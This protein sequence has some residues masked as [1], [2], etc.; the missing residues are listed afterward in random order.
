MRF[1]PNGPS[2]PDDLLVARDEGRVVFFC[3]A[4][5]SRARAGLA[6]FFGLAEAVLESLGVIAD[7]PAGKVLREAREIENRTGIGLVSADRI[8]GLLEREFPTRDIERAVAEALHPG[9]SVDL[10]AHET[11]L[12]LATT[13]D[14][15]IQVVTTN[16]DRLFESCRRDL[17]VAMPPRLPDPAHPDGLDGVVH[18]HG[19]VTVEYDGSEGDGFVLSSS[20]FG[21]AYLSDGWATRF[22]QAILDKYV[23]VFIGYTADDPPVQYLLEALNKSESRPRSMYAFQG[24]A[25]NEVIGKWYYK[26]VH[27]IAYS[28]ADNHK[29]LWNTLEAWAERAKNPEAWIRRVALRACDGPRQLLPYERGQVAHLVSTLESARIF[30]ANEPPPPAEWLCVFDP[31]RRY[32]KPR[33]KFGDD[34]TSPID[35]FDLYGL[36]SDTP[37]VRTEE[38]NREYDSAVMNSAWDAFSANRLDAL[39]LRRGRAAN[40]RGAKAAHASRLP[41][42]VEQLGVW[43]SR[44]S[45]EPTSAWWAAFQAGLH[46]DVQF[47]IKNALD[48]SDRTNELAVSI[49][50][51]WM[52]LFDSW[53]EDQDPFRRNWYELRPL[54]VRDGWSPSYVRR[55][56]STLR[57]YLTT[58][59]PYADPL[60]PIERAELR[61]ADLVMV[62]VSYPHLAEEISVP[63]EFLPQLLREQR[64]NLEDAVSLEMEVSDYSLQSVEP[65]EADPDDGDQYAR[66]EGLSGHLLQ[67]ARSFSRLLDFDHVAAREEFLALSRTEPSVFAKLRIWAARNKPIVHASEL[68]NF[69]DTLSQRAFWASTNQRDL[70]LMLAHRWA[71]LDSPTR[72]KLEDRL[73]AGPDPFPDEDPD[74]YTDR[75][76]WVTL[77]RINWL[78]KHGCQ[79]DLDIKQATE[80]L[81]K[82][83][84]DWKDE[85]ADEA[86]ERL[87][88]RAGTVRTNT[89]FSA[90]Q[91]AN[92]ED[93]LRIADKITG[94][95]ENF[96]VENAPFLGL[97]EK[98][99]IRA[100]RVLLREA[101]A[102]SFPRKEW[103]TFFRADIRKNDSARL[104]TVI[105]AR[106]LEFSE[107][108]LPMLARQVAGWLNSGD[109]S[110]A[111]ASPLL[112]QEIVAKLSEILAAEP[113]LGSSG[114]G[115]T[116]TTTDWVMEAINSAVGDIAEALMRD[117][118]VKGVSYT[119]GFPRAW[120]EQVEKILELPARLR[121]FSL[122]MFCHNLQWF[123]VVDPSWTEQHLITALQGNDDNS[124]AAWSGFLWGGRLTS[125]KLFRRLK[126]DVLRAAINGAVSRKDYGQVLAGFALAGW[127]SRDESGEQF[128][129]DV[130]MR[131]TLVLGTEEF[132]LQVLW[133]LKN[134]SADE[135]KSAYWC[136]KK[137]EFF[138]RVWPRQ[139]IVKTPKISSQLA[140]MTFSSIGCFPEV[141]DAVLPLLTMAEQDHLF[142]PELRKSKDTIVDLHPGHVGAVLHAILPENVAAWP[143]GIGDILQRL[144]DDAGHPIRDEKL[145]ELKRRWETR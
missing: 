26:G 133:H 65:I 5:V 121:S 42:R 36:D 76:A 2:I 54:V 33:S 91:Q 70:L 138:T 69:F 111:V 27:G 136:Q 17:K 140:D 15:K 37:P 14:G 32:A 34:S 132:R 12:N 59:P 126:D 144:I 19:R 96:L 35:P 120:L 114:I 80:D 142:L 119:T 41:P 48:R 122:V 43:L 88:P 47:Q 7:D 9:D 56:S 23:V 52:Y 105:A 25:E 21:R 113:E 98:K 39:D 83:T 103:R 82:K 74:E 85:Y 31:Y 87:G 97:C 102:S 139:K 95:G 141:A 62:D 131:N 3:G 123:Y 13:P 18:L 101:K 63:D 117:P 134:W 4:G 145:A 53:D 86:A 129:S 29:A 30:A 137:V 89:D 50:R 16:F 118:S 109:P 106:L 67:Y 8:F 66:R 124:N 116:S 100:L 92:I 72:A 108:L 24:G 40:M 45:H 110:L 68:G 49:R 104:R 20:E 11:I 6:N 71:D 78:T 112:F 107:N 57:A 64:R 127:H 10:S 44:V 61:L 77:N 1:L 90:L 115:R 99:P 81:S 135:S 84:K 22:F 130:E 94:R 143:W 28:E 38:T 75:R 125:S 128:V 55:Y 51:A 73:I 58:R 79:F 46:P 60:P 93:V